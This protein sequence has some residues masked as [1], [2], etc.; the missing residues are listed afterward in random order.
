MLSRPPT[1]HSAESSLRAGGFLGTDPRPLDTV[2][3]EDAR[4]LAA[5]GITAAG[6]AA[7]LRALRDAGVAGQGGPVRVPPHFTVQ[8]EAERGRIPCPFGDAPLLRKTNVTVTHAGSGRHL[9]FTDLHLHLIE[10][11]GFFEGR[12]APFRLDPDAVADLLG[13]PTGSTVAP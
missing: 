10:A 11:H 4:R 5:R 13:L 6:L 9:L 3:R 8:A 1:R 2:L 12:G 7:R